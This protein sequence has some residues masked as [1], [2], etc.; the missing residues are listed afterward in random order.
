VGAA[1]V[2]KLLIWL[3]FW[4]LL[5]NAKVASTKIIALQETK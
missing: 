1:F 2:A 5:G 3:A 4:L